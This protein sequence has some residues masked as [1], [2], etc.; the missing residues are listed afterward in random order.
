MKKRN[1]SLIG[2]FLVGFSLGAIAVFMFPSGRRASPTT[3][4][5]TQSTGIPLANAQPSSSSVVEADDQPRGTV[6]APLSVPLSAEM[7]L[8][9][10]AE[11]VQQFRRLRAMGVSD[12]LLASVANA[13]FAKQYENLQREVGKGFVSANLI[14]PM[15][16][17]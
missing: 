7:N 4:P 15:S 5:A 1:W 10:P 2:V 11:F 13:E 14:R 16:K 9:F 6:A 12:D 8:S 17:E 3:Q